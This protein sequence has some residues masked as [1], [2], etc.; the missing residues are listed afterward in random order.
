M[1]NEY[2][3]TQS[4]EKQIDEANIFMLGSRKNTSHIGLDK[5]SKWD[6]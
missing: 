5:G 6:L 2:T 3:H 1:E 4:V